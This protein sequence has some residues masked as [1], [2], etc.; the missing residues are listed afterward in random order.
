MLEYGVAIPQGDAALKRALTDLPDVSQGSDLTDNAQIIFQDLYEEFSKLEKR[1]EMYTKKITF[2]A[3]QDAQCQVLMSIPGIKEITATALI[4]SIG[5]FNSFKNGRDLA[6]W[7]GLVP[8]H[9]ASGQKRMLLGISK[10]GDAYLRGLL[11]HGARSVVNQVKDKLD[12]TS[13]WI[14]RCLARI[15][16][17][18]T[19]VA[20][21]NKN[22]RTACSIVTN[23]VFY[24]ENYVHNY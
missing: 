8:K 19:V 6:A 16:F 18:K 23:G 14:R 1:I 24:E 10:R 5:D 11:I 20:L 7:V 12:S 21:A 15:G 17:N 22:A 2:F 9:K 3:K 4:S 13:I